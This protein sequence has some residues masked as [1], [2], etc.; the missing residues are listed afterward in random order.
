MSLN[1]SIILHNMK[2]NEIT[3]LSILIPA[4]LCVICLV[5]QNWLMAGIFGIVYVGMIK[6]ATTRKY[7]EKT[8][9]K[10]VTFECLHCGE[11]WVEEIKHPKDTEKCPICTSSNIMR[12]TP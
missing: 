7:G 3:I 6:E 2:G 9:K 10:Y 1:V 5:A 8:H 11:I 12:L 4:I